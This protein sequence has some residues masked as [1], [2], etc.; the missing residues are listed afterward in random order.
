MN[1]SAA[2]ADAAARLTGLK[3]SDPRELRRGS[4]NLVLICDIVDSPQRSR[5]LVKSA[6]RADHLLHTESSALRQLNARAA[7]RDLAPQ[8][9]A[10]D[11]TAGLEVI[12]WIDGARTLESCLKAGN[13]AEA[14]RALAMTASALGRLHVATSAFEITGGPL[15]SQQAETFLHLEPVIREFFEQ[16]DVAWPKEATDEFKLIAAELS[17]PGAWLAFTVGDMAPSNILIRG[18]NVVFI[19]LEYAGMRHALYDAVFWRCICPFPADVVELMDA[20]Y[21]EGSRERRHCWD[22]ASYVQSMTLVA[23]HRALWSITWGAKLLWQEDRVWAPN[24]S[25]RQ[26]IK[27]WLNGFLGIARRSTSLPAIFDAT[28]ALFM[29]LNRRWPEADAPFFPALDR[30]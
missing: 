11:A 24:A 9:L 12:E 27:A 28:S 15:P 13:S 22:E 16:A 4:R 6:L 21:R 17:R 30:R 23:A 29:E 19:D 1:D 26:L 14:R 2:I 20:A 25:G 3:L 5:V 8:L 7:T 18:E 10:Y